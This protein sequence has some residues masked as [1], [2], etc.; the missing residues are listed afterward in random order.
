MKMNL[1]L[2]KL[3]DLFLLPSSSSIGLDIGS[4]YVKMIELQKKEKRFYILSWGV[5]KVEG[6]VSQAVKDVMKGARPHTK[7]F[8]VGVNIS[9]SGP[10]VVVR[11][12]D[13]PKM[14]RE[15]LTKSLEF[16]AEK[17]LPFKANEMF[18]DWQVLEQGREKMKVLL[19]A[20]KKD[21]A[22]E[23]IKIVEKA[24]LR[25]QLIDIDTLCLTNAFCFNNPSEEKTI[26][27]LNTG[28][29]MTNLSIVRKGRSCLARDIEAT[30]STPERLV[31]EIGRCF[32]FYESQYGEGV[33]KIYLSGGAAGQFLE[34]GLNIEVDFWNPLRSIGSLPEGPVL[35]GT[36]SFKELEKRKIEFAIAVGLALR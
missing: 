9:L 19:C 14:T 17:Y 32:D 6:D 5:S 15:E 30:T 2:K 4:S 21:F 35:E 12:I 25:V 34:Q 11:Y 23:K 29:K 20:A 10:N 28:A 33:E 18:F 8:G 16:E 26:C 1:T 3:K 27:L 13:L 7:N 31:N 22:E 36:K 24:G